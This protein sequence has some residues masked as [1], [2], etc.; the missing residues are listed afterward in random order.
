MSRPGVVFSREQLLDAVGAT[1]APSPTAPSTSTSCACGRKSKGR[2]H[3]FLR[4]VRG[5]GYSFNPASP[6]R[7]LARRNNHYPF[8]TQRV[9]L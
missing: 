8:S 1:T 9:A 7:P 5:F 6:K 4:S 2:R 3:F